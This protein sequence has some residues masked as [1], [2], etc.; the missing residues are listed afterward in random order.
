ML[1]NFYIHRNW[2]QSFNVV[3]G[4]L[5]SRKHS[6]SKIVTFFT[7]LT[8]YFPSISLIYLVLS[9]LFSKYQRFIQIFSISNLFTKQ[10]HVG[11][12]IKHRSIQRSINENLPVVSRYVH[13]EVIISGSL[14]IR[15]L[16]AHA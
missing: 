16:I 13:K 8:Q 4:K 7:G 3:Q 10:T 2:G 14:S 15:I 5:G 12:F 1:E 9:S 11:N 6:R